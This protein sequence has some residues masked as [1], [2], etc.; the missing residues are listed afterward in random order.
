MI[1]RPY[2]D[3]YGKTIV[4]LGDLQ[5]KVPR[6]GFPQEK[7]GIYCNEYLYYEISRNAQ[8]I[9]EN[10]VRAHIT[11]EVGGILLGEVYQENEAYFVS[12][13][14][15]LPA[16]HIISDAVSLTFTIQTWLDIIDR[17]SEYPGQMTLGWYH[18]HPGLGVF[19][20]GSDKFIHCSFFGDQPWYISIVIDPV[21]NDQGVYVWKSDNIV[22]CH[23]LPYRALNKRDE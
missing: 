12:V 7:P 1:N 10:H 15:V 22:R 6:M 5:V 13:T 16:K 2:P 3:V 11:K 19:L 4:T 9:L 23:G 20:S 8:E 17:R 21:S 14:N 18:S